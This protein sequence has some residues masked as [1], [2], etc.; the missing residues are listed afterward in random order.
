[1]TKLDFQGQHN[2]N[3]ISMIVEKA[4]WTILE[5]QFPVLR[6]NSVSKIGNSVISL[7]W[8]LRCHYNPDHNKFSSLSDTTVVA[9]F[10]KLCLWPRSLCSNLGGIVLEKLYQ[11]HLKLK[12]IQGRFKDLHRNLYGLYDQDCLNLELRASMRSAEYQ[13]TAPLKF[14]VT[15][16]NCV[17]TT[18]QSKSLPDPTENDYRESRRNSRESSWPLCLPPKILHYVIRERE[19][20]TRL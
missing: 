10:P 15:I 17:W 20:N 12:K 3:V 14:F 19:V 5:E 6:N 1:M 4:P 11:L 16:H 2:R 9:I 18:N 7:L 13:I 8:Q